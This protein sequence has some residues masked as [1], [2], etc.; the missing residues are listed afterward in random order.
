[1]NEILSK[2]G[3]RPALC[4]CPPGTMSHVCVLFFF[5]FFCN[6]YTFPV[7]CECRWSR[8]SSSDIYRPT[9]FFFPCLLP[10]IIVENFSLFYSTEEDQLLSYNDL[11]HFQII[12]NMVDDKREVGWSC[13]IDPRYDVLMSECVPSKTNPANELFGGIDILTSRV[14]VVITVCHREVEEDMACSL[15]GL[16]RAR[17]KDVSMNCHTK[18]Q[19]GL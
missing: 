2:F 16:L 15:A 19:T 10:A 11:R 5:F 9:L 17:E 8:E 4:V 6:T 18:E 1:M 7:C 14:M 3:S 12:W 13:S